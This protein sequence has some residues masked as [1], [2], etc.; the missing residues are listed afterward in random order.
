MSAAPDFT[1]SN[2]GG[3]PVSLYKFV[4]GTQ[5]FAYTSADRNIFFQGVTYLATPIT[6]DGI[7]QSPEPV[8]DN[9]K[10]TC[11]WANPV[12]MLFY[13]TPPSDEVFLTIFRNQYLDSSFFATWSGSI[14]QVSRTDP[15]TAAINCQTL[16]QSFQRDGATLTYSRT[17]PYYLYDAAT[18]TVSPAAHQLVTSIV[19]VD[20]QNVTSND[21]ATLGDNYYTGGYVE[22]LIPGTTDTYDRRAIASQVGTNAEIMG[23]TDGM[24]SGGLVNAYPGCDRATTT[25]QTKFNNLA[26]CGACNKL[27]GNSPFDGVNIF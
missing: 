18:C 3:I 15:A 10:V 20:G 9:V 1:D 5:V 4:R 7:Q 14:T 2:Y 8:D 26:N 6:D 12:A 13:G 21:F 27:P 22:W 17:C 25:C 24:I 19:V 16:A 11:P 23:T